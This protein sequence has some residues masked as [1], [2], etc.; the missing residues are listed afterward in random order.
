MHVKSFANEILSKAISFKTLRLKYSFHII[1]FR[2]KTY[3]RIG[4]GNVLSKIRNPNKILPNKES[5]STLNS[6]SVNYH[7]I[8]IIKL[9]CKSI[10]WFLYDMNFQTRNLNTFFFD[11]CR[12]W[13][14]LNCALRYFRH[15]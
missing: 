4:K 8:A 15:I 13:Q 9:N 11:T 2:K 5:Y 12:A 14:I 6:F 10:Y 1:N 7:G 3:C